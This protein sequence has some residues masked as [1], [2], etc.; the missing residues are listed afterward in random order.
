MRKNLFIVFEG[1]DGSGK[2]TQAMM[3]AEK[4]SSEGHK[5]YLTA[6]PTKSVIGQM[7]RNIFSG[8]QKANH[9]V[10]AALFVAD[11]LQHV[12]DEQ[13]GMIQKLKEGFTVITDRYYF[14]SYAYH[15]AHVDM[16]WVIDSNAMSAKLLKPD[17]NIFL[18][19]NIE[20][21]M[22]RLQKGREHLEIFETRE[23]LEKVR[24]KYLEA[25]GLM[26]DKEKIF[27]TDGNK[28]NE[29]IANAIVNYLEE[30]FS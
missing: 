21:S 11:R 3:L 6:E 24:R 26:K 15:G 20:T 12:M 2:S 18:D 9:H 5:V 16:Q 23:N 28:A 22:Q 1:I 19:V 8:K 25:F 7:I 13:D 10:I 4:L 14:S 17:V 29:E 30:N 27:V